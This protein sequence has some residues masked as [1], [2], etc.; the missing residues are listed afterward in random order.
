MDFNPLN[1]LLVD[2]KLIVNMRFIKN[3]RILYYRMKR[4]ERD[5]LE[6]RVISRSTK[7]DQWQST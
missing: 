2:Y 1:F 5:F 3:I 4:T 6:L 7:K